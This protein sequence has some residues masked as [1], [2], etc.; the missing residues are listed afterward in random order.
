MKY[1]QKFL[2][3]FEYNQEKS[4]CSLDLGGGSTQITFLPTNQ[5]NFL[6]KN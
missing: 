1:T 2:D 3:N 4:I 6:F 5:V